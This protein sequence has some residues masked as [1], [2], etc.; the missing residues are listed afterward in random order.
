MIGMLDRRP[1]AGHEAGFDGRFVHVFKKCFGKRRLRVG[2][3]L[4]P[5]FAQTGIDADIGLFV[6]DR[7]KIFAE[8]NRAR[9][10][11]EYIERSRRV[12]PVGDVSV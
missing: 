6:A 1:T 11:T 4:A 9:V 2:L 3:A 10:V 8:I 5:Q 12:M 7:E